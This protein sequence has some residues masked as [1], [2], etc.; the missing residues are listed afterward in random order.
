MLALAFIFA[1][2]ERSAVWPRQVSMIV[3]ALLPKATGGYRPIGMAP[4]IYRL[5]AK[6]RRAEAD[7]W[8]RR[9]PRPFFS[10]T[11][12][13]GPADSVWRLA[14]QQEAGVADGHVA[15]TVSEDV[16]AFF[17]TLDRARLLREA[18]A[19]GFPVPI[20]KAALAAYSNAR[21]ISMN[22]RTARECYPSAGIVA[23]CSLAMA[24]TKVYSLRAMDNLVE[25]VPKGVKLDTFVDD[26]TLAAIGPPAAVIDD[27][28]TAHQMMIDMVNDEM[29]CSLAENKTAITATAR[30]VAAAIA[31]RLRL[32]GGTRAA[33]TLLGID[34]TAAACRSSLRGGSRKAARLKA[35]MARKR[36]LKHLQRAIGK[37]AR[38]IFIA[39]VQPAAAYGGQVWG[40]D[41]G[42]VMKLR[43]LAAA[44]LKP[45]GKCRSLQASL[46]WHDLPTADAEHAPILQLSRMV[47]RAVAEREDAI[48][49]GSSVSDLRQWWESAAAQFGPVVQELEQ[50]MTVAREHNEELPRAVTARLWRKV[51]GPLAA[52]ALTAARIGW[53]FD[54]V[55]SIRD[56]RG[57]TFLLTNTSPALVKKLA[58]E[59]MKEDIER[60]IAAKWAASEPRYHGRRACLDFVASAVRNC[61]KL[62]PYQKGIM[63]AVTCGAL[64]TG[65]RA[66]RLGYAVSGMC[67]LCGCAL[68][69]LT[70]RVYDCIH[71]KAAVREAVPQWFWEEASRKAAGDRFWT[72]GGLPEPSRLG[73]PAPDHPRRPR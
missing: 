41:D 36:R 50:R 37:R 60:R 58:A 11:K 1:A 56:Q 7:A 5:W 22:G 69:T 8:E 44:A 28:T 30:P 4:A 63:R 12:G 53:R 26:L 40:F 68:D 13:N 57:A 19:L 24:L 25:K 52:A 38:K 48:S 64:M 32:P 65:E 17:E 18:R 10:A 49:R 61:S 20:V 55:F 67:P 6:A 70:H 46:L 43:R 62:S 15:A 2:V 47:W 66:V 14:A 27:L 3:A 31:R 9:H 23:G 71:T 51:R 39:G 72:L 35:A 45:S 73:A 42:E 34:C 21:V 54:D 29:E 16:Q 59:A 33:A